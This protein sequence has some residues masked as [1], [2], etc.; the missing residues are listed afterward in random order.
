MAP[1]MCEVSHAMPKTSSGTTLTAPPQ[2]VDDPP[3]PYTSNSLTTNPGFCEAAF[4]ERLS[5]RV[6]GGGMPGAQYFEP[7][8]TCSFICDDLIPRA[9]KTDWKEWVDPSVNFRWESHI[10]AQEVLGRVAG[11]LLS[12]WI[13]WEYDEVWVKPMVA[14]DW[15]MHMK[16]H[17]KD[18]GYRICK[19]KT[20]A[21]Q[22]RRNC[23]VKHC[24]KIHS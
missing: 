15:Y 16:K 23:G 20:G 21:M 3:P 2:I 17:F 7:C 4:K 12:C 24:P 18:D 6:S 19:G 9:Y 22:R 1:E 14:D 13:C 10:P 8:K 5:N 11:E